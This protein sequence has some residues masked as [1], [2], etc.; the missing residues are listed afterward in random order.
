M[1]AGSPGAGDGLGEQLPVASRVDEVAAQQ[2][3]HQAPAQQ[4]IV[5]KLPGAL[6]RLLP[7][8]KS[9][10]RLA[11]VEISMAQL[12]ASD[13]MSNRSSPSRRANSTACSPAAGPCQSPQPVRVSDG[14]Q[15]RSEEPGIRPGVGP[16]Q[17]RHEQPEGFLVPETRH[18]V[19]PERDAEPQDPRGPLGVAGR[20]PG[21]APQVRLLGVQP[22]EPPA[23]VR[24]GQVRRRRLGDSQEVR[25]VRGARAAASSSPASTSRSAANWR[26]VSSSR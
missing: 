1:V 20:V 24:P 11:G 5:A 9:F 17:R 21:S 19:A 10:L 23:L 25:A 13:S 3:L 14:D 16:L 12:A 22:R 15:C 18:P 2:V 26:M 4:D 7:E 6:D 8:G